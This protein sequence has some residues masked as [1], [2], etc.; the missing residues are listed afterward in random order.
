M[1]DQN[2]HPTKTSRLQLRRFQEKDK[3]NFLAYRNDPEVARYQSWD[4][5]TGEQATELIREM[6]TFPFGKPGQGLQIAI[7]HTESGSLVGDLY[8]KVDEH[9]PRQAEIGFTLSHQFQGQGLASEA[10]S[11]LLDQAF[12]QLHL[13]RIIAITDARNAS[14]ARLLERIGFRR[15]GYFVKN[16]WFKNEWGD[17][18]LYAVLGDEWTGTSSDLTVK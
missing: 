16:I 11:A 7:E 12:R 13:H 1:N 8:L 18:Y 6:A 10:L 4:S 3:A 15:E 9:E 14:A 2:F 17:E 5:F